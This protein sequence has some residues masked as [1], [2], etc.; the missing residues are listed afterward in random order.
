MWRVTAHHHTLTIDRPPHFECPPPL[1][2]TSLM[3]SAYHDSRLDPLLLSR[4]AT[5]V[6][7]L[8][9]DRREAL[10]CLKDSMVKVGRALIHIH[11][12]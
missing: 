4:C 11:A 12:I 1:Q 5:D 6:D 9:V 2:V 10:L 7:R 8:C 3:V